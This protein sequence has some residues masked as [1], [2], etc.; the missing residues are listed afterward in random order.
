MPRNAKSQ[1]IRTAVV[2]YGGAYNMGKAHATA[3][4]NTP[5]LSLVA[6]CDLDPERTR[7]AQQDWP[8][9]DVFTDVAEMLARDD[10][11]LAVF[12]TPHN[13]HAPLAVQA[14]QAGKHA[15]VE[16]PMC[17]TAR[18]ATE[19]IEAARQNHRMLSVYHNRRWD[20]DYLTVRGIAER[21]ILGKIFLVEMAVGGF[22]RAGGWRAEKEISG[23]GLYD[24]GAHLVDWTLNLIPSRVENVNGFFYDGVHKQTIEDHT[25]VSIRFEN[26][27][28][29][30]IQVSHIAWVGK[31]KWRVLGEKGGLIDTPREQPPC[32]TI[33]TSVKGFNGELK[34]PYGPTRYQD[35]YRGISEH[36]RHGKPVP[37]RPEDARRVI[38]VIE[39]AGK[40]NR[41][42]RAEAVPYED[43]V[44]VD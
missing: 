36:L 22:G 15:I 10:I 2:G 38:A 14:L 7:A 34:I 11:D 26:G 24:W 5:G 41:S 4:R 23:G 17:I 8:G 16:K 25:R 44:A 20:G 43:E 40:S 21:G 28:S 31:P 6:V 32:A 35:F 29:A 18:E 12:V 42:G 27:A 3:V 9:I 39:A 1:T 13:T 33:R 30:D 19:M 37:V